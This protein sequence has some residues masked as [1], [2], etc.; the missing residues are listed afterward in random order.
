MPTVRPLGAGRFQGVYRDA[1]GRRHTKVFTTKTAARSWAAD[2][3]ATVR[4]G[5]H[6]NPRAG[7]VRLGEW[8]A[9]WLAARV[10]EDATQRRDRTYAKVVLERWEDWPL[11]A[12]TRMDVQGWV[13]DMEKA[14]RGPVAIEVAV[15]QLVSVLQ[16]A[17]DETP[18]LIPANPARGVR[19]PEQPSQP[20]RILTPAEEDSL[21]AG[22]PTQQDRWMGEVL[23]DTGL[24]YGELAGLHGHRVD[25]LR[26]ELHVV[27]VL[28]QAGKLKAYPKSLR[29]RRVLPLE[30]RALHALAGAM[31]RWGRDGLVF[32]TTTKGRSGSPVTAANWRKRAFGPAA[33]LVPAPHPTPHDMRHTYAT[34]LVAEGVDLRTVQAL[35]GHESIVT[36]ERYVHAAADYQ[37]KVR[38]ALRRLAVRPSGADR[39]HGAP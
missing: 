32:R 33:L 30:D 1:S 6:R 23:A 21:L 10:V 28:T 9:R 18:P 17:V 4:A 39:A 26:R 22:L 31:E 7:R 37:D 25:M 24:R 15:Q 19:L 2:G 29:S 38:A 3:E 14:G 36:T 35:L 12:I 8:H 34:R 16:A 13:A 20:D 5:T 27:E 11:D